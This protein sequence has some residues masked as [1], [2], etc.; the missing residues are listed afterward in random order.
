MIESSRLLK[1]IYRNP[2]CLMIESSI[3]LKRIY[4]NPSC[5]MIESSILL[6]RIYRNPSCLM[7]ESS[8]LLKRIYRN[9]SCL[10]I[11]SSILLKRIYRTSGQVTA[12]RSPGD[13]RAKPRPSCR[14]P[15][16]RDVYRPPPGRSVYE[17]RARN[18]RKSLPFILRE[19]SG[20]TSVWVSVTESPPS[21]DSPGRCQSSS[22]IDSTE[23]V[24]RLLVN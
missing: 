21:S 9:P 19:G 8:I 11:E 3:L 4:R 17:V 24:L 1:R 10:M 7:I 16:V 5:L 23:D 18:S 14:E 22:N 20:L 2:S 15:R 12:Q 6:K 13:G